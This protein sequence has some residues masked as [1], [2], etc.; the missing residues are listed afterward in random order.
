MRSGARRVS[1]RLNKPLSLCKHRPHV[2]HLKRRCPI[3]LLSYKQPANGYMMPGPLQ[4]CS[5]PHCKERP[6]VLGSIIH[7]FECKSCERIQNL[8]CAL[9]PLRTS[10][11]AREDHFVLSVPSDASARLILP[12]WNLVNLR[13]CVWR[14]RGNTQTPVDWHMDHLSHTLLFWLIRIRSKL[15]HHCCLTAMGFRFSRF[16]LP[17]ASHKLMRVVCRQ[18][19]AWVTKRWLHALSREYPTLAFH[20][21]ITNPFGESP[22]TKASPI[23]SHHPHRH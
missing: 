21:S 8:P 20:A 2:D 1:H 7:M 19:P 4:G 12:S 17:R 23:Q 5:M 11:K 3:L 10:S 6:G 22:N 14:G 16:G 15:G 13:L 9:S 18:V